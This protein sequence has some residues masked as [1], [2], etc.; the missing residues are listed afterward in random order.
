MRGTMF[1]RC[2]GS[3]RTRLRFSIVSDANCRRIASAISA[4]NFGQQRDSKREGDA[5]SEGEPAITKQL[6]GENQ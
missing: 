2:G 4:C 5:I 6:H 1:S 3:R